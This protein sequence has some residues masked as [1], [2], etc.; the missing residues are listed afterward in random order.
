V[1]QYLN[2]KASILAVEDLG[3]ITTDYEGGFNVERR[4]L[5]DNTM[6]LIYRWRVNSDGTVVPKNGKAIS[7]TK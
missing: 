5:L 7:I 4:M 3:W 6:Q 2:N 1:N